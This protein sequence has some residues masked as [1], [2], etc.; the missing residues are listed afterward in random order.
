VGIWNRRRAI[1]F[2]NVGS[3]SGSGLTPFQQLQFLRWYLNLGQATVQANAKV[4]A[5]IDRGGLYPLNGWITGCHFT[6]KL[7]QTV[8][9]AFFTRHAVSRVW[10][11]S[12]EILAYRFWVSILE[13]FQAADKVYSMQAPNLRFRV[14]RALGLGPRT[15]IRFEQD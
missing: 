10:C 8:R 13:F 7:Y 12:R 11:P 9:S 4:L 1:G 2:G 3:S 15:N 5:N 6:L 14:K